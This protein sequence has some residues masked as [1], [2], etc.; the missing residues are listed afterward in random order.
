MSPVP[1]HVDHSSV[2]GDQLLERTDELSLL[3]AS[4]AAARAGAGSVTIVEGPAG[5][6]KSRLLAEAVL[7][8]QSAGMT[9]R[10]AAG[11]ELESEY[12]AGVVLDLF[13]PLM[14]GVDDETRERLLRGPAR[15]AEPMFGVDG[16]LATSRPNAQEFALIHGLYWLIVN[17]AEDQ[18]VAVIVDD[19]QWADEFSLRFLA[20]LAP[21]LSDLAVAFVVAVRAD[22][23]PQRDEIISRFYDASQGGVL[24]L[25]SLSRDAVTALVARADASAADQEE[26]TAAVFASTGGNAF[27]VRE[28]IASVQS[29]PDGW[30][31]I[32]DDPQSFAPSSVS[33][34]VMVRLRRFGG[35][36]LALA[37]AASVLGDGAS[38]MTVARLAHL[39]AEEALATASE[40]AR[41]HV[42]SGD[43]AV[44]FF[45][46]MVRA[47]VYAE[48]PAG[49]RPALHKNAAAILRDIGAP[50]DA[51]AQQVILAPPSSE[52]WVRTV[53]HEGARLAARRG[54]PRTAIRYLRQALELWPPTESSSQVSLDLAL[55]EAAVGEPTS[56]AR[57]VDALESI[58][59]PAQRAHPL[60]ALGHTLY[61]R[62][63]HREAAEAFR[64]G[65]DMFVGNDPTRSTL[66]ESAYAACA[67]YL[68]AYRPE[69]MMR[70]E[71]VAAEL[72][73]RPPCNDAERSM[74]GVLSLYRAASAPGRPS[75][76]LAR[77]ALGD[78]A[79]CADGM[80]GSVETNLAATALIWS[81]HP[82]SALRHMDRILADARNRGDVLAFAEASFIRALALH[83][84]GRV[85]DAMADA[86]IA[87]E[88]ARQG[89]GATLPGPHGILIDCLLERGEVAAAH[90]VVAETWQLLQGSEIRPSSAWFYWARG[91]TRMSEEDP[92]G[93]LDDFTMA[94]RTLEAA[95][96][97]SPGVI[98]WRTRA[99]AAAH[100]V[101]DARLSHDLIDEELAL[102]E[103]FGLPSHAA[104]ALRVRA[105]AEGH[106]EAVTTLEEAVP[107]LGDAPTLVLGQVL[108]DLGARRRRAGHAVEARE[109]LRR[110]L[111]IAQRLGALALAD[112]AR[113]ELLAS[114]ARPRRDRISGVEA[115][116]PS[117]QRIAQLASDGLSNRRI[118]ES[119][120]LTKNTVEWHL[121][122]VYR[123]LGIASRQ[124]LEATLAF[125]DSDDEDGLRRWCD[126]Q[127]P[128]LILT[129]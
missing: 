53:L 102:A 80:V 18:P 60:Y 119:L 123:K 103:A 114:G 66:F 104:C 63:R 117:E 126:E 94:G 12:A 116:T 1:A 37:R 21:R 11:G 76:E 115:L 17:L 28:L 59:D 90:R 73:T 54:S 118:A 81:G 5:I 88:G 112:R 89:W 78:S 52:P 41:V 87:I 62:G 35:G 121:R 99:A 127:A 27:L 85:T 47:A 64:E 95:G 65:V 13:E 29:H 30:Q 26:I 96:I 128:S 58:E 15:T 84:V 43:E 23:G 40:L 8:A 33:R 83:R 82:T 98:A 32:V 44:T 71:A 97:R 51:V 24:R 9:V 16:A 69:A 50:A 107:L 101:G 67:H 6:G 2:R 46:P 7:Q 55:S 70:L 75:A 45:H 34:N 10:R 20:Y 72:T 79:P 68:P 120:F 109:E 74:L 49:Q 106:A 86:Q 100:A 92:Q 56:A 3:E 124:E 19:V 57:F 4:F 111:E 25:R 105:E 113:D 125:A 61:R 129:H 14:A 36:A 77:T 42:L 93:G 39:D 31:A 110:A 108:F 48:L 38:L 22:D 122:N 91:R